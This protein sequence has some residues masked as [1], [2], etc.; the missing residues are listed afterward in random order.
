M[1]YILIG[2]VLFKQIKYSDQKKPVAAAE[3]S[4]TSVTYESATADTDD[5]KQSGIQI[6]KTIDTGVSVLYDSDT[7][8]NVQKPPKN[9]RVHKR[10]IPEFR[11]SLMFMVLTAVYIVYFLPKLVMMVWESRKTTSGRQCPPLRWEYSG[12]CIPCLY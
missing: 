10:R 7:T 5:E 6:K 3:A 1:L 11:I 8:T 4:A 12:S 2:R 9:I